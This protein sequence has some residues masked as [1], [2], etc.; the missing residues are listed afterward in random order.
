MSG[1]IEITE[2]IENEDGSATV[3]FDA[4]ADTSRFLIGQGLLRL[5]E[6]AVA[7]EEG[8]ELQSDLPE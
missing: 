1:L 2:Y 6:K 5:L 8:Y 4:N 7:K 3:K